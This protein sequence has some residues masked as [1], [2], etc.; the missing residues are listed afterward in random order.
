MATVHSYARFSTPQQSWGDSER[1]QAQN[2]AAW[3]KRQGHT[4]STLR[5]WDRGKSAFRGHKQKALAAFLKAVETGEVKAGDILLVEAI[6]RLG[7]KGIRPTQK[8][9]NTILEAGIDIAILSPVEKTYKASGTNDLGDAIELVAF[10]YQAYLYSENL[11]FRIK[12]AYHGKRQKLAEGNSEVRISRHTPAWL[13]L[14]GNAYIVDG[15]KAKIVRYV[16]KRAIDGL[17]AR[18]LASELNDKGM[19]SIGRSGKWNTT[20]LRQLIRQRTVLGEYQPHEM[21]ANGKRIPVGDALPNY[22]PRII[23]DVT[24]EKANAALDNRMQ[25]RCEPKEFVNLFA[26]LVWNGFD[27]SVCHVYQYHQ[28]R[29]DGRKIVYRRFVSSNA[30]AKETGACRETF[31]IRSFEIA[32]L[33]FLKEVD[34]PRDTANPAVAELTAANAKLSRVKKRYAELEKKM[35]DDNESVDLLLVPMK[36][37]REEMKQ[38]ETKVRIAAGKASGNQDGALEEIGSFDMLAPMDDVTRIRLREALKQ[39]IE[40]IT[41]YPVKT[42][43]Q[44]RDTVVCGAVIAFRSGQHR[45]IFVFDNVAFN[46]PNFQETNV[47]AWFRKATKTMVLPFMKKVKNASPDYA[48][49]RFRPINRR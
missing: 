43:P 18:L 30:K 31:D 48:L 24:W 25:E 12:S 33:T 27:D 6:D 29:A 8:L 20:Y 22:Y 41:I 45:A 17:G 10:A 7:R 35:E 14:D 39:A 38:L 26:G 37:L 46:I 15:E 42:G 2:G 49:D 47:K 34:L 4:F 21:A 13:T 9:V 16:F 11:S 28:R 40:R 23:D 1:R 19:F 32:F 44:R 5:F 36:N 3:V